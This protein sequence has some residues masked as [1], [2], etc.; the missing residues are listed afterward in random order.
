M[1]AQF[2]LDF[3]QQRSRTV[4]VA[5]LTATSTSCENMSRSGL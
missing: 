4:L 2:E 1:G 3:T 5:R